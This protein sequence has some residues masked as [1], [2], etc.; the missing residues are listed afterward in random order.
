MEP[1]ERNGSGEQKASARGWASG[2]RRRAAG[3]GDESR[4]RSGKGQKSLVVEKNVKNSGG[5]TKR[6]GVH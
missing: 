4:C 6:W 5:V 3:S 1:S 2:G